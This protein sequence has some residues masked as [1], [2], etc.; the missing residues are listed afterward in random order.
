LDFKARGAYFGLK[1]MLSP[2]KKKKKKTATGYLA[3]KL[4]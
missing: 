4:F 3:K 2:P 1:K